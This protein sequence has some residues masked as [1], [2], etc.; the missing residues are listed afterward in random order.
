MEK[1]E[2]RVTPMMQQYIQTKA[3][4][5]DYLLFYRMG[6]FYELF[7][8]DAVTASR[9]LDITLTKRGR[10]KGEDIPMCGVPFHAYEGY[11]ARLVKAGY[12]VA[13][14]EQL[15]SPEEAKKA[16]RTVKRDVVRLVTPG[17]LTEE[18]LLSS[19]QYNYL[20]VA[21]NDGA[22]IGMMWADMSTGD[23]FA[24]AVPVELFVG[25]LARIDAAEII[26]PQFL[27]D[28]PE[29]Q[30]IIQEY[31]ERLTILPNE[32]FN[33]QNARERLQEVFGVQ[34]MSV[35]GSF[36]KPEIVA[37]GVL[38]DYILLTQ[39][40]A[41]PTFK[42]PERL[43]RDTRMEIDPVTLKS[44]E[45][46]KSSS[47][48]RGGKSLLA[49][50][51]KTV[52]PAGSRLF[53]T[54]L[55]APLTNVEAINARLDCVSFFFEDFDIRGKIRSLLT[56]L[57]DMER[58]FFRLS[59]DRGGPRDLLALREGLKLVPQMKNAL[60]RCLLPDSLALLKDELGVHD[61]LVDFLDRA[62]LSEVP[63]LARD[64]GFIEQGYWPPLD[65]LRDIRDRSRKVLADYQFKYVKQTGIQN[66]KITYNNML[67]Y[68]IEVPSKHAG[69]LLNDKELGF[70]HRQTMLNAVRFTTVELTE[71]EEKMRGANEK[72][73]AMELDLFNKMRASVLEHK[74]SILTAAHAFAMFDVMS[75]LA[76]L[77]VQKGYC[78]P[79]VDNSLTFDITKGRHPVV[80]ES[81]IRQHQTF[82]AND[83]NLSEE[84]G[85]LWLLTGPN[86]AGKS[87]FLRQNALI[88]IMAQMGSFVPAAKAHIGIV[89][90]VFSRVGASDDLARG[91][92]T[93][94]VEMVETAT[95]LNCATEKSLVILDEIGRGT[96]TFDGL[97]IAWAVV[98]YLH[99]RNKCRA[100]F[101]THYH[102]LAALKDN[103]F[104]LSLH[105][106]KTKEWNDE[107]VFLH[108]VADG[109]VDKSYGIH[110][111]KL[112]GLP[113][114]VI[115]R[116]EKI[117]SS[118]ENEKTKTRAVMEE[119]PL[120]EQALAHE[121]EP[122]QSPVE[123][124]LVFLNPDSMTP[125]EALD[126]I[127]KLKSLLPS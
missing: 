35:F 32:R 83:C 104:G 66:L 113:R 70:I 51:D 49:V 84:K 93:F 58:A 124:E 103:L 26:L 52:T 127:Y 36:S 31:E 48:E 109:A 19:R 99:D 24:E 90:K 123:K 71:L 92:S 73:L 29:F 33:E 53:S 59:V 5:P 96:A 108:T 39:K 25:A 7:F 13:I 85:R 54:Y 60:I 86:M 105:T 68:F 27:A 20:L 38:L 119:L 126:A 87:T 22:D 78:R 122:K 72:I 46:L 16:G 8:D 118:L 61:D 67:G 65:E 18:I 125:R 102:E 45:L 82:A 15:E 6:D 21:V 23:I 63:L 80:E 111:A 57:P 100:I 115:Q 43:T 10:H 11:L 97:S 112:A 77:A 2:D 74:D 1:K 41:M 106:M 120:F 64:G 107:V 55:R 116:A 69:P 101:A 37:G 17:T 88:A 28:R 98:E 12:K 56:E 95:I 79:V 89:D 110:V 30:K 121:K 75:A 114:V 117:L 44:L 3:A 62:L 40:G 76:E 9:V 47:M 14:C 4:Y 42:T 81:L 91:Q 50:M 94:M 34:T